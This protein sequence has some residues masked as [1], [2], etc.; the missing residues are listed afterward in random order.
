MFLAVYSVCAS[1]QTHIVRQPILALNHSRRAPRLLTLEVCECHRE[2]G[3]K[4]ICRGSTMAGLITVPMEVGESR[5]HQDCRDGYHHVQ[6]T[7]CLR[8]PSPLKT[9]WHPAAGP[10]V[11]ACID[12]DRAHIDID[13]SCIEIDH[14]DMQLIWRLMGSRVDIG[15]GPYQSEVSMYKFLFIN[16]HFQEPTW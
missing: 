1:N 13:R 14:A 16:I 12:I 8:S 10:A 11:S 5:D 7:F 2:E 4:E 3:Y 6:V 15:R 9:G